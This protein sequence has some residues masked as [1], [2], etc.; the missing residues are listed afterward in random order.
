MQDP[1]LLEL[2]KVLPAGLLPTTRV[3]LLRNE[4]AHDAQR[5]APTIRST[6][7]HG[8]PKWNVREQACIPGCA[9]AWVDG[10]AGVLPR[11]AGVEPA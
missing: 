11:R 8:S 7:A 10:W 9:D 4:T 2:S 3:S 1:L 6:G 5:M